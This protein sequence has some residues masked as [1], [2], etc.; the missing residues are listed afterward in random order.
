MGN[1]ALSYRAVEKMAAYLKRLENCEPT[2]RELVGRLRNNVSRSNKGVYV[3][4]EDSKAMY[5]GRSDDLKERILKHGRPSY[6]RGAACAF[7]IAM[8]FTTVCF[9]T[10]HPEYNGKSEEEL[11]DKLKDSL[12]KEKRLRQIYEM[13]F[14][15]AKKRIRKMQVRVVEIQDPNEQAI[16]EVYAHLALE[17]PYN[18]FRNH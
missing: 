4:Y 6:I 12:K 17:T 3:F 14:K 2:E 15:N 10:E 1:L 8:K 11:R 16:L 5:V 9:K 13:H 18:N 7:D